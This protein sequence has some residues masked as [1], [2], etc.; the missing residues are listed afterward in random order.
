MTKSTKSHIRGRSSLLYISSRVH[1]LVARAMRGECVRHRAKLKSTMSY[2]P[3]PHTTTRAN[4]SHEKA[5]Q[6]RARIVSTPAEKRWAGVDGV[7]ALTG[8]WE[9]FLFCLLVALWFY[10]V[11]VGATL[12]RRYETTLRIKRKYPVFAKIYK[13]KNIGS[14]IKVGVTRDKRRKKSRSCRLLLFYVA[15]RI[16]S[17]IFLS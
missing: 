16:Y 4:I 13:L 5:E 17:V 2:S 12:S 14:I 11:G 6:I 9:N 15:V 10:L 7:C 1:E 8:R 3:Q